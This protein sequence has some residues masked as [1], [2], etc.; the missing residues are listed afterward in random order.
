MCVYNG[1][2]ATENEI[3]PFA[4]ACRDLESITVNKSGRGR[5][6]YSITYM[7]NLKNY[8]NEFIHKIEINTENKLTVTIADRVGE[9]N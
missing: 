2:L 4:A 7:Q 3:M 9:I 8:T 1:I 5:Q 6:T